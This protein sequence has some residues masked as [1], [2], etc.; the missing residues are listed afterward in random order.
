MKVRFVSLLCSVADGQHRVDNAE[1][2]LEFFDLLVQ[3]IIYTIHFRYSH[4]RLSCNVRWSFTVDKCS[5][6]LLDC[7]ICE[8]EIRIPRVQKTTCKGKG[9]PIIIFLSCSYYDYQSHP[10]L[11]A[12][13]IGWKKL[14]PRNDTAFRRWHHQALLEGAFEAF[15]IKNMTSSDS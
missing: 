5:S 10:Q 11:P 6:L 12:W 3:N 9:E 13:Q 8:S 2:R 4:K 14:E 7:S 15:R 1:Q